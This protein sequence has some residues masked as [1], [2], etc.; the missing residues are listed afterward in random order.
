LA[1]EYDALAARLGHTPGTVAQE[2]AGLDL[3]ASDRSIEDGE[4]Q[5]IQLHLDYLA[6]NLREIAE[7]ARSLADRVN[8]PWW[9]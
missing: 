4:L 1:G 5:W 2:L 7:S 9:R 3:D 8:S 6:A